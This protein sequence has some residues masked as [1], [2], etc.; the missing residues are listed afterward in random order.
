MADSL[1]SARAFVL[2]WRGH[3]AR[4]RRRSDHT[5]RAYVATAHRLLDFLAEHHGGAVDTVALTRLS[6]GDLRAFLTVRRGAGLANSSAARELSAV[7]AFLAFAIARNGGAGALPR[8]R[9]PKRPRSIPR[10]IS[11][12][13]AVSLAEEVAE[14]RDQP[15]VAARD[16]A[17]LLLLYGAGLRVAEALS[18]DGAAL[19]FGDT[20]KV[21]G[22]RNKTRIVPLLPQV[23]EAI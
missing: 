19:P 20:L 4:D 2:D 17:L 12:T 1:T 3:L 16:F 22:K 15:W 8:V 9:G 10:P 21:A 7:R 13:E 23:R 14:Q 5:V 11:P 6:P 18:L